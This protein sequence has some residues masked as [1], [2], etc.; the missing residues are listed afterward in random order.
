MTS[1]IDVVDV[2][3]YNGLHPC[4]QDPSNEN[5]QGPSEVDHGDSTVLQEPRQS[6]H[7]LIRRDMVKGRE[8]G[9][10]AKKN[11]MIEEGL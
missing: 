1:E 3:G 9:R 10:E 5:H 4:V 11:G 6:G 8:R 2:V 7:S